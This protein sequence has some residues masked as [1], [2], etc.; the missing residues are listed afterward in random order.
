M[1]AWAYECRPADETIGPLLVACL[2]VDT[3]PM[4]TTIVRVK[5]G[6][7]WHCAVV[8]R[9]RRVESAG[10]LLREVIASDEADCP[11]CVERPATPPAP[12]ILAAAAP[13]GSSRQVDAAAIAMHGRQFV[14]VLVTLDLL[15][16]PGEADMT[17]AD[18][19]PRF[20]GVDVV[21]MG[22]HEDG[23]PR[24]HGEAALVEL[25][26]NVPLDAMPWKAYP[27]G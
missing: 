11:E 25:L 2:A 5:V 24:Y 1:S 26:A 17:I 16:S 15:N 27:V 3:M 23:T 20:G 18:L 13:S 6:Q 7:K 9:T 19:R 4:G 14:I 12:E 22:Q 10:M 21:L 8:D